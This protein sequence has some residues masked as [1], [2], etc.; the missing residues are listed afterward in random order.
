MTGDVARFDVFISYSRRDAAFAA[1]LEKALRA[2]RPPTDLASRAAGRSGLAV[3]RDQSD[4]GTGDYHDVIERALAA[5]RTLVVLCSPS[6]RGSAF[7]NDEIVRFL[8]LRPGAQV[9]PVLVEGLANNEVIGDGDASMA[10]PSALTDAMRM[11]LAV[12]YR[13]FDAARDRIDRGAFETSWFQLLADIFGVGRAEIEQRERRRQQ[14]RLRL[15][16]GTAT[17]II[18]MLS[19]ALVLTL[20]ARNEAARQRDLAEQ[21]RLASLARQLNVH[22]EAAFNAGAQ[23][24]QRAL[25]LAIESLRATWTAEG[26]ALLL[27]FLDHMAR[28][29]V[30]DGPHQH[31]VLAL[32]AGPG[33]VA[34]ESG[35]LGLVRKPDSWETIHRVGA[36]RGG[37]LRAVAFSP[38]GRWLVAGCELHAACVW[39]TRNWQV[40]SALDEGSA[41][42]LRSAIFSA[43]GEM[44]ATVW[45]GLR[46][47]QLRETRGWRV[48]PSVDVGEAGGTDVTG[49]AF[50]PQGRLLIVKGR[51]RVHWW[52]LDA[53]RIAARSEGHD[54]WSFAL[55]PMNARVA[56]QDPDRRLR[57]IVTRRGAR[58][59]LLVDTQPGPWPHPLADRPTPVFD[60]TGTKL[61]VQTSDDMVV[62]LDP[63][64][65]RDPIVLAGAVSLAFSSDGKTLLAGQQ[66]G[67]VRLSAI[68][69]PEHTSIRLASDVA[70]AALNPDG[71]RVAV[72][73]AGGALHVHDPRDGRTL[74]T[75]PVGAGMKKVH[76]TRSGKWLLVLGDRGLRVFDTAQWLERLRQDGGSP[77]RWAAM[78]P[79]EHWLVVAEGGQLR[80]FDTEHWR[81]AAAIELEEPETY[82][83]ASADGFRI[84]TRSSPEFS[85]GFGLV[86]PSFTRVWDMTSGAQVAWQSHEQQDL[87]GSN[88]LYWLQRRAPDA[89]GDWTRAATGGD[90]AVLAQVPTWPKLQ[91]VDDQRTAPDWPWLSAQTAS[92]V[93][94]WKVAVGRAVRAHDDEGAKPAFSADGRWLATTGQDRTLRVW[95]LSSEDLIADACGRVL[96]N[97]TVEEWTAALG[98]EPLRATC[99]NLPPATKAS[100]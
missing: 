33:M 49:A 95:A 79:N 51:G 69:Q 85:R 5:S 62:V 22:A 40:V 4:I 83:L 78:M 86:R 20:I 68:A 37:S 1:R 59:E 56:T 26:H 10:F 27:R 34:T 39:D 21:R 44:L 35:D 38:D 41:S 3:F 74:A 53:R 9:I 2:F 84:A 61:A 90:T 54:D 55:D 42:V 19:V 82:V 57:L 65:R 87:A 31:A 30:V 97:L 70:D 50:S 45:P 32:A 99:S 91:T 89:T 17:A 100:Q 63:T 6:A 52:D 8:R 58:G 24:V 80:R 16:G 29:T 43:D 72:L 73:D 76:F 18:A 75:A 92:G 13:R 11:P 66:D 25:L 88:D 64:G 23:G 67:K 81:E 47:V 77:V 36:L 71:S 96:R 48:L 7:V 94:L 93:P 15:I 60:A 14:R 98:D 28:S 12:D 46:Q